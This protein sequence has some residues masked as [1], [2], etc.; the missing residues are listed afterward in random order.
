MAITEEQSF[1]D[2]FTVNGL[3]CWT[4]ESIHGG[5][6]EIMTATS[7]VAA[8]S[9]SSDSTGAEA[10]LISPV[11]DMSGI[12]GA[13]LNFTYAMMGLY[14]N[15]ELVVCY[16]SAP[17]DEW[18]TLNTYSLN[19]WQNSYDAS[20][21]IPVM[22]ATTQVSFLGRS[23]GGYY[24]FLDEVTVSSTGS[25]LRPTEL[26][27]SNIHNNDVTVS[28]IANGNEEEWTLEVD[29]VERTINANPYIMTGL[30]PQSYYTIRIRANCGETTSDWTNPISF[31]TACDAIVVTDDNPYTDD[32]EADPDAFICWI[33]ELIAGT[34]GWSVDENYFNYNHSAFFIWLGE[35]GRLISPMFDLTAVTE[36]TL[37]FKRQQPQGQTDVDELSVWYRTSITDE[38][39]QLAA[40][41]FPTDGYETVRYTLPSPSATYQISFRAK[42]NGA[43]GVYVDDVSVGAAA[44]LA[45][46][47]SSEVNASVFPNP[48][49]D[50]VTIQGN[51]DNADLTVFDLF[52]KQLMETEMTGSRIELDLSGFAAGIYVVRLANESGITTLKVVKE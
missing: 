16:R 2:D 5:Q 37:Q 14:Q 30:A 9:N 10:R 29:G 34:L 47:E 26:A 22:S 27:V 23:L 6:W 33:D 11:L 52:G 18:H 21:T 19:D 49:T 1:H 35:E 51:T 7:T 12:S 46:G 39:H 40:F 43:E 32:F 44:A 4:I 45:I 50:K 17:N 48:T 8:F 31:T 24:I 36:P 13:V 15:D 20:L 38:W 25:C 28:W 3:D 41:P 42:S